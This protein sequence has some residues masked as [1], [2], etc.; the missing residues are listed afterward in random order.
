MTNNMSFWQFDI[1]HCPS[2]A[3]SVIEG[4]VQNLILESSLRLSPE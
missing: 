3:L 1:T 2:T 4:L